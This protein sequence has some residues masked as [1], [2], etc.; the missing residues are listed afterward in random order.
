MDVVIDGAAGTLQDLIEAVS[1]GDEVV[2]TDGERRI[3]RVVALKSPKPFV[4]DILADK[5]KGP[6]PDFFEPMDEEELALWEGRGEER[7]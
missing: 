4:Y 1:N 3:A 2:I 6:L 7:P 5:V